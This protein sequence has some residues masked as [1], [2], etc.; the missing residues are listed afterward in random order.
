MKDHPHPSQDA[1]SPTQVN[2]GYLH[3]TASDDTG[4]HANVAD[5]LSL[6]ITPD[7]ELRFYMASQS[8]NSWQ[9]AVLG[10]LLSRSRE[11]IF[12]NPLSPQTT[13]PYVKT[14][15]PKGGDRFR[16]MEPN[17]EESFSFA[18][19]IVKKA[20]TETFWLFFGTFDS[21]LNLYGHF[22]SEIKITAGLN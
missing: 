4:T 7:D 21:G 2:H 9:P 14:V 5:T 6:K 1:L 8:G 20:G 11:R 17:P 16:L 15:V 19:N 13:Y 3:M 18:K 10:G 22:Y 12:F